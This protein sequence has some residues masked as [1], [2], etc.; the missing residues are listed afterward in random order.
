LFVTLSA[1]FSSLLSCFL[2]LWCGACVRWS[3]G[4]PN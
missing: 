3:T 2:A 4:G 1:F